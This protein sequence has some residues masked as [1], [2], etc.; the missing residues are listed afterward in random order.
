MVGQFHGRVR[1]RVGLRAAL[2]GSWLALMLCALSAPAAFAETATNTVSFSCSKVTFYFSG[3][4]ETGGNTVG[5][6]V[7]VDG[8]PQVKTTFVFKGSSGS[9]TVPITVSPGHHGIDAR[10]HWNTNG[11]RGGKDITLANGINCPP[12]TPILF[13]HGFEGSGAQFES[14]A[15]RFESNGYPAGWVETIDYDSSA[16][17]ASTTQVD[18][19]IDTAIAKLKARTGASQ[20]ILIGHSLG[21]TVD[22]GYLAEGA[23]AAERDKNVAAYI[24]IDGQEKKPPVP[25]LALW[26]EKSMGTVAPPREIPG[27]TNVLIP[28]ET[29]VQTATSAVSFIAMYKYLHGTAPKHDIVPQKTTNEG[30]IQIAGRARERRRVQVRLETAGDDLDHHGGRG[31]RRMGTGYRRSRSA[32]RVR[33]RT[34]APADASHLLPGLPAKRLR[35][36]PAR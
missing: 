20:V 16:A 8:V 11:A 24:N 15:Q 19:Q 33:A 12:P 26:A 10:T 36:P 35:G 25:T 28:N 9:N 30:P 7:F 1:P 4:P 29:H 22:Y 13:V 3:F 2:L 17:A 27:A 31:R 14:Q 6:V 21:T 32:L 34:G 18:E 5:E 23:K